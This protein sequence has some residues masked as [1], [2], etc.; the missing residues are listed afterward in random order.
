M[1]VCTGELGNQRKPPEL[2]QALTAI[3]LTSSSLWD[4]DFL[5]CLDQRI[6]FVEGMP[7]QTLN[8][9]RMRKIHHL[10]FCGPDVYPM[11]KKFSPFQ[12]DLPTL[13]FWHTSYIW[14]DMFRT[15]ILGDEHHFV[16]R[17]SSPT[18]WMGSWT[19]QLLLW[20]ITRITKINDLFCGQSKI[21][22]GIFYIYIYIC[23]GTCFSLF[24]CFYKKL[25][26][27][28]EKLITN[29]K[30][31]FETCHKNQETNHNKTRN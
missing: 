12:L 23:I 21:D 18:N 29:C 4:S 9:P 30:K 3:L 7:V 1:M 14:S 24:T 5:A 16:W 22:H 6:A 13:L 17:L 27:K 11:S 28:Y 19:L 8:G 25:L 2:N 20:K 31:L 10:D 26:T 15:Y